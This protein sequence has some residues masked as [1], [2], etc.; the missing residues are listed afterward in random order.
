MQKNETVQL[1]TWFF[2]YDIAEVYFS[3]FIKC[4]VIQFHFLH[5]EKTISVF[6]IPLCCVSL[7]LSLEDKLVFKSPLLMLYKV[8]I[9]LTLDELTKTDAGQLLNVL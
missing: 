2:F 8:L 5:L 7:L 9:V 1:Y 6:C 4:T 3:F